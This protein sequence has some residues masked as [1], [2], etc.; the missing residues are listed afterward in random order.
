M[1]RAEMGVPT[2]MTNVVRAALIHYLHCPEVQSEV[3]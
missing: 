1:A 2:T 3:S